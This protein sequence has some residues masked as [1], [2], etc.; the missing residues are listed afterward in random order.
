MGKE[1]ETSWLTDSI[2]D[3]NRAFWLRFKK[4]KAYK[5]MD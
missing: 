3:A 4:T 1:Q 2:N 5:S